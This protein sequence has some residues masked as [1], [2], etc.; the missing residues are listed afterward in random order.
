MTISNCDL[1][2]IGQSFTQYDY[3]NGSIPWQISESIKVVSDIFTSALT[4]FEILKFENWTLKSRSSSR[5]TTFAIAQFYGKYQ[6][7]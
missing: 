7:L 2:N 3:R 4:V 6:N 5:S 1:E